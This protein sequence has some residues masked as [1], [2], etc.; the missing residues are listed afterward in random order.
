[1]TP[2]ES[3]QKLDALVREDRE[4]GFNFDEGVPIRFT[5]VRRAP[6]ALWTL[7]WT[8]HHA[9]LDGRSFLIVWREWFALYDG[10]ASLDSLE[11]SELP[12]RT[13]A[14]EAFW[15]SYLAGLS[16]TTGCVVDR[17]P[18]HATPGVAAFAQHGV[19]LSSE[20]TNALRALASRY[21]VT[22]S[23][24]VLAAWALL[25]SRYSDRTEVVFGVTCSGRRGG[26]N[27]V[28]F[29]I[30]TL[31]IR[32]AFVPGGSLSEC[33]KHIRT[34]WITARD[35]EP[36]PGPP[37]LDT[38]VVY[39][40][41][42][43]G[44]ALGRLAG[45]WRHR[46]L[47]RVQRAN[48]PLMLAAYGSPVL[49]LE[50]AFD[51]R[52][53][54]TTT[55]A[56]VAR[57]LET[58][59]SSFVSQLD[60]KLSELKMLTPSEEHWLL[61]ELNQ[62]PAESAPEASVHELFEA[63]VRC[64]PLR[65]AI[66][67]SG[68]SLSYA[69]LNRRANQLARALLKRG[70]G[71]EQI[72]A[73]SM[74]ASPD[75]V[76]AV[77]AVLKAGAAFLPLDPSLPEERLKRMLDD[78]RPKLVLARE[79]DAPALAGETACAT[80]GGTGIQP[81]QTFFRGLLQEAEREPDQDLPSV[82]PDQAAYV[83][84]TSG[85]SGRPKG[86]V[87][88]H[89]ALANHARAAARRCGIT[90]SDRRLQFASFASDVFVAELF[91]YLCAGATLVFGLSPSGRTLSEFLRALERERIT[92][93]GI[94][95]TWWHE[96]V[97]A[98]SAGTATIPPT[99]RAV[100]AGMER[101]DPASF[102]AW[103]RLAGDRVGFFNAYGPTETTCT[104]T[105]YAA[106]SSQWE[107]GDHVPIGRPLDNLRT[108]VLDGGARPVPAG[109]V[110]ELYL[111]GAGVARGY[112]NQSE[113]N[114]LKF[115]PDPFSQQPGSRMYRTGDMVFYLPDGNLVFVGRADRQVKIRGF[116]VELDEIELV[117]EQHPS[118]RRCA[119]VLDPDERLVAY[120]SGEGLKSSELR[121]HL[122]QRL[123]SYMIPAGF[124]ILPE[125]PL[126]ATGKI[127][128]QALPQAAP[129][130]S[131][132]EFE[133]PATETER[134]LAS[135]WR[136]VLGLDRA[137]V[138]DDF[139]ES[140]GDSLRAA[141]LLARIATQFGKELP[142][143]VLLRGPTIAHLAA[144]LNGDHGPANAIVALRP[145]GSWPPLFCIS[146]TADD[147]QCF[148]NLPDHLPDEQPCFALGIPA[149][150]GGQLQTIETLASLV[151]ESIRSVRPRGPYL[152][153]G[154][155]LG[156]L[157]AFEA[158]QQLV[159]TGEEVRLVALFDTGAPGYPK[160][161]RSRA[162]YWRQLR[163][164]ASNGGIR[165]QE[166]VEH[167]RTVARLIGI[168]TRARKDRELTRMGAA[169]VVA[170]DA[171]WSMRLARMYVPKPIAV[172]L[173]QFLAHDPNLTTR[174]LDDPRLGWQDLCRAGFQA[175]QLTAQHGR[176]LLDSQASEVGAILSDFADRGSFSH[177]RNGR[178][179]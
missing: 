96:W 110:G 169:P 160:V 83:I 152:L 32:V 138:A 15:R 97:A 118:V 168:K 164:A 49:S 38:F 115:L 100:I 61:E 126:T 121:R 93:T 167:L 171:E 172:P 76:I 102:R 176:L 14:D 52:L 166:L 88:T 144:A 79:A 67:S 21:D 26:N 104:A 82:T 122:I 156:G 147:P 66:E 30:K 106:G 131:A 137:G 130:L 25:L 134:A 85:S 149:R 119:V 9:L 108:Y 155:C 114:A 78:A 177:R 120:V 23:T 72:V 33:L 99:L 36:P 175:H 127:D 140:G 54:C 148:R 141:R 112:L 37:P 95:S 158:A 84:Y 178:S 101:V 117:L 151:C 173:I 63:Q 42:A 39:D 109:V 29:L 159:A 24:L 48:A 73:I 103:K 116:R 53:F 16:A 50:I 22:L 124:V 179:H 5:L 125:M 27:A 70:A 51:T 3:E 107:G 139:F 35:H 20:Q 128:R 87:V 135:L 86:V 170:E 59:L 165:R 13:A 65:R 12:D 142:M 77:L 47:R 55:I 69:D 19:R 145:R 58:L 157:V 111:G 163:E 40:H 68:E 44:E 136:E 174:V 91:N 1:M 81:V 161:L 129:E 45:P 75:A 132:I 90:Q 133:E 146:S 80:H 64:E 28:G 31:P 143:A 2:E 89:G 6:H 154:V 105:I 41:E 74:E 162:R 17:L 60:T 150:A 34:D 153:A 56:G 57:H 11:R 92:V 46:H 62:A 113:A 8:A 123:P 10:T 43:P 4:R 18:R 7:I 98:L 71:P 94:P